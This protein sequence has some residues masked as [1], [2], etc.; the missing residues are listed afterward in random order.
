MCIITLWKTW[1]YDYLGGHFTTQTTINWLRYNGDQESGFSSSYM[2]ISS[3]THDIG[4]ELSIRNRYHNNRGGKTATFLYHTSIWTS[5]LIK[6]FG[7]TTIIKN[8]YFSVFLNSPGICEKCFHC[9]KLQTQ[10][11]NPYPLLH[12]Q[13][14]EIQIETT[15]GIVIIFT[16]MGDK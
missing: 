14:N 10:E 3:D 11:T 6:M 8:S 7:A 2:M 12:Q 1:V 16:Y 15:I 9:I 13:E 5:T 4:T